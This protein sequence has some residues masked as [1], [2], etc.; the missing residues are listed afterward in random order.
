VVVLITY[1]LRIAQRLV[2]LVYLD[3]VNEVFVR[4]KPWKEDEKTCPREILK[5]ADFASTFDNWTPLFVTYET[6]LFFVFFP[7]VFSWD[8]NESTRYWR[9]CLAYCTSPRWQMMMMIIGQSVEWNRSTRR[10]PA[11][12]SLCPP[13][14]PHDLTWGR[15][16]AAAVGSRGL[17]AWAMA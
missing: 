10:K 9:H 17:T 13:Q 16:W 15:T 14:I 1:F 8:E 12:V 2:H 11:P 6:N 4:S 3:P 7:F 5:S